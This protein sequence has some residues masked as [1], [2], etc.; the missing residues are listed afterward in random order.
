MK[1][2]NVVRYSTGNGKSLL[3]H[4]DDG[5]ILLNSSALNTDEAAEL[6]L[7]LQYA[8][9]HPPQPRLTSTA[10]AEPNPQPHNARL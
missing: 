3:S 2:D 5:T 4:Y 8:L 10:T 9:A 1:I 6:L 7:A